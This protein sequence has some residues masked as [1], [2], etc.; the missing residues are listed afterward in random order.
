MT[1]LRLWSDFRLSPFYVDDG[2][3]HFA[4]TSA[5]EVAEQFGL[6]AEVVR[7]V[8]AWDQLYQDIEDHDSDWRSVQQQEAYLDRGRDVARLLRRHLPADVA[9]EYLADESVREYY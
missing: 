2:D 4:L 7:A 3:G 1:V 8:A 6:P 9:I 5:A